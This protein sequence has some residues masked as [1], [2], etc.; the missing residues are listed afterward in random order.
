[1]GNT[2]RY[3]YIFLLKS[4]LN[5]HCLILWRGRTNLEKEQTLFDNLDETLE[6]QGSLPKE[7]M[8]WEL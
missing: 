4:I 7:M 8:S 6:G 2:V 3:G 5:Q 1:M